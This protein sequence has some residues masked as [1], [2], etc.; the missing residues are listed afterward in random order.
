[1]I[2]AINTEKF[3]DVWQHSFWNR[4]FITILMYQWCW[5]VIYR[6]T[7]SVDLMI[8]WLHC[9]W[10]MEWLVCWIGN[11]DFKS[12]SKVNS[13]NV[14]TWNMS[15]NTAL[16]DMS[17]KGQHCFIHAQTGSRTKPNWCTKISPLFTCTDAVYIISKKLITF[18][19]CNGIFK[20]ITAELQKTTNC[21]WELS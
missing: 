1:M 9:D 16:A 20:N 2:L 19:A 17:V 5:W 4:P 10:Q 18:Y 13:P 3:I 6:T 8:C 21:T 15:V 11:N 7:I 12:K 14:L